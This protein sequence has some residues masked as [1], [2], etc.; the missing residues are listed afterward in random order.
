M[1]E[2]IHVYQTPLEAGGRWWSVQAWGGE[3]DDARWEGWLV[4]VPADGSP[5]LATERETTQNTAE[6]L[7]YWAS[8]LTPTYLEGAFERAVAR[9]A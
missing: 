7:A 9:A 2:V 1:A 6:A 3:R 4:F 8:G 5:P